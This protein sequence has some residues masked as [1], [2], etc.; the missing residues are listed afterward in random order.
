[1]INFVCTLGWDEKF[2]IR[3]MVRHG[4]KE[5]A[6]I[7]IITPLPVSD[8]V[9]EAKE[10]IKKFVS[11]YLEGCECEEIRV[12]PVDFTG[13]IKKLSK[14]FGELK[15]EEMI[16]NLSG[17]MRGLALETFLSVVMSD[18][19]ALIE[20]ELE[21]QAGII[22]FPSN[23]LRKYSPPPELFKVM[24]TFDEECTLSELLR[25]KKLRMSKST[26]YRRLEMLVEMGFLK[27]EYEEDVVKYK[28][29]ELGR[30]W[31]SLLG[32]E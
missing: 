19:R 24:K 5:G 30:I 31:S 16:V 22:S 2:Q 7:I 14:I 9:E 11:D 28:K 32:E 17:G 29:T 13:T 4:I 1:M 26:I 10:R 6:K 20:V 18:K 23:L 27:K 12:D 8:R 21:N 3:S 25:K 15:G